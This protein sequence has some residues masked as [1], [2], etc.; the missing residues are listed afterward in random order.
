MSWTSSEDNSCNQVR[1]DRLLTWLNSDKDEAAKQYEKIRC[2]LVKY[3]ERRLYL[4]R[5]PCV[6]AEDLADENLDR[7]CRKM[8]QLADSYEGDPIKYFYAVAKN[9]YFEYIKKTLLPDPLP[10]YCPPP[11][12]EPR[13]ECLDHCMNRLAKED[14]DL[15][16]QYF[17]DDG[18]AKIDHRKELAEILGIP[19]NTFRMRIHRLKLALQE[20]VFDCMKKAEA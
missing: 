10:A 6:D 8:P 13:Q 14:S 18:K 19:L 1:F 3:F 9:I 12:I 4:D 2:K 7:V 11:D 16:L 15:L 17:Q 5:Y 20:C